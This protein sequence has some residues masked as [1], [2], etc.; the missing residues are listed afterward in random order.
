MAGR[1]GWLGR[2]KTSFED[3]S[4]PDPVLSFSWLKFLTEVVLHFLSEN[5]HCSPASPYQRQPR[6]KAPCQSGSRSSLLTCLG[7]LALRTSLALP[8]AGPPPSVSLQTPFPRPSLNTGV[9]KVLAWALCL[10]SIMV[11][12]SPCVCHMHRC[13]C[14]RSGAHCQ[15]TPP[16]PPSPNPGWSSAQEMDHRPHS[17]PSQKPVIP[18]II[19]QTSS[20]NISSLSRIYML[21]CEGSE[22]TTPDLVLESSLWGTWLVARS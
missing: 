13:H 20:L 1:E 4:S 7:I 14:V 21:F 11:S 17:W 8:L 5:H 12:V 15:T 16:H 3:F 9:P 6:G 18:Q 2:K 22:T 19:A 10:L